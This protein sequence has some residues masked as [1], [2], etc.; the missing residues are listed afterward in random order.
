[1]VLYYHSFISRFHQ[2]SFLTL[3]CILMCWMRH[4]N[5]LAMA[6]S[7]QESRHCKRSAWRGLRDDIWACSSQVQPLDQI[8]TWMGSI[9]HSPRESPVIKHFWSPLRCSKSC[10]AKL[11]IQTI[12]GRTDTF[13][14]IDGL[15]SV[16]RCFSNAAREDREQQTLLKCFE[17]F[18]IQ[19]RSNVFFK[20]YLI[21]VIYFQ[22]LYFAKTEFPENSQQTERRYH[23][24][25]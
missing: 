12:D 3:E 20:E 11:L 1:M 8:I 7:V 22:Y 10:R 6:Y 18:I 16:T 15:N 19:S 14:I 2:H 17:I 5:C 4:L 9:Y 23:S 21:R 24:P 13:L 25:V